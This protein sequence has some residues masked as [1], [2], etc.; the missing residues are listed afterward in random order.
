MQTTHK[1]MQTTHKT[2][3]LFLPP[4]WLKMGSSSISAAN[5]FLLVSLGP[6]M[7]SNSSSSIFNIENS[8]ELKGV[9]PPADPPVPPRGVAGAGEGDLLEGDAL[10]TAPMPPATPLPPPLPVAPV[11]ARGAL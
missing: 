3:T 6:N 9:P 1:Y 10:E 5:G 4:R 7:E 8:S 11:G 2:R